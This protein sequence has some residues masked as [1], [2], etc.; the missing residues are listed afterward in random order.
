MLVGMGSERLLPRHKEYIVQKLS[1]G[2]CTIAVPE[3][4]LAEWLWRWIQVTLACAIAF[5]TS[6]ERGFESLRMHFCFL[7]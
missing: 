7:L 5:P 3:A 1:V 6:K 2:Y 4:F